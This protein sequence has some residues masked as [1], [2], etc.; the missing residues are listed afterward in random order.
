MDGPFDTSTG[1]AKVKTDAT[2]G[3]LKAMGNRQGPHAL[4]CELVGTA[5]ADWFGLSVPDLAILRLEEVDCYPLPRGA[6]TQ[7]GPALVSKFVPG[8]TWGRSVEELEQL[9]NRS[10]I[11]RLVVFDNWVR[12]CDRHPPNLETRKPN[13]A[14]VWLG[15]TDQPD[16]ARLY[17]I[18]HTHCF[19]STPELTARLTDIDRA[20]DDGVYGLFPEFV[21]F[22]EPGELD[23]CR[24]ML[25]SLE[26]ATVREIV[27][28]IPAE[29][30]VRPDARA[31]LAELIVRRA[32]YLAD[33]MEKGWGVNWWHSPTE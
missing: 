23:W 32:G 14:N 29:W 10:D 18:D 3:Y 24:A 28:R 4:A 25:R 6:R 27:A 26:A 7:P 13:Y 1:T 2:Y 22:I 30:E 21:T 8:K 20:K 5:L 9:V 33:K 11:T 31:A 17:A 15:H 16:Q 12:N 19:D